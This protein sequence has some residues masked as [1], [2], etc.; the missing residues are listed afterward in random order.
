M[1]IWNIYCMLKKVLYVD[2]Q[3]DVHKVF[4]RANSWMD[5]GLYDIFVYA[6]NI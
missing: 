1:K 5:K 3:A 6:K 2:S 4:G